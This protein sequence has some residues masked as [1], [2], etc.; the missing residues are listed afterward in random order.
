MNQFPQLYSSCQRHT[1]PIMSFHVWKILGLA[2]WI[3]TGSVLAQ[4][5]PSTT[6]PPSSTPPPAKSSSAQPKTK[7]ATSPKASIITDRTT[8][9]VIIKVSKALQSKLVG[10]PSKL[11]VSPH[12]V[13][14]YAKSSLPQTRTTI[15][16]TLDK[17]VFGKWKN[18]AKSSS[19]LIRD[20]TTK[21]AKITSF[22]LLHWMSNTETLVVVDALKKPIPIGSSSTPQMPKGTVK[23]EAYL[24]DSD[25]TGVVTI[26]RLGKGQYIMSVPGQEDITVIA[27]STAAQRKGGQ[28]QL[29]V[30]PVTDG[31]HLL[32]PLSGLSALGCKISKAKKTGITVACGQ[33]SVG[34]K[35]IVF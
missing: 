25:L 19:L 26:N 10:C 5:A 35:P 2:G 14:L 16:S 20:R 17:Q 7:V 6:A 31:K 32:F 24:L 8:S 4:T 13:C 15:Q 22:V 3:I 1:I 33:Q 34:V 21:D 29:N 23:G 11:E 27:G 30:A 18:K 9:A 12:G 28:I